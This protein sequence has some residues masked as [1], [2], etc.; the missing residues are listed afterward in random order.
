MRYGWQ[1]EG[2]LWD[3]LAAGCE[4]TRWT[5]TYLEDMYRQN[6]PA[7]PGVYL[8]CAS[9]QD[10]LVFTESP[11]RVFQ[12]LYNAIY[13]GQSN[14]LRRRFAQH[15]RGYGNVPR[16]RTIFRR[17]DYW[18]TGV[19]SEKLDELEQCLINALGPTANDRNVLAIV[20]KPV[21][22]GSLGK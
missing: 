11:E 4:S 7:T 21:P 22:A 14:N 8:I 1:L 6:V 10:G 18:Y 13:V 12:V 16:A 9:A 2:V 3:H 5:R 20:G 19:T 17:L 15:V